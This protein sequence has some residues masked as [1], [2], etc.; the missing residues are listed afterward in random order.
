NKNWKH[1]Y[2]FIHYN[3][4]YHSNNYEGIYWY[5]K[6]ESPKLKVLTISSVEQDNITTLES[7]NLNLGDFTLCIPSDMTKTH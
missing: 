1:N 6:K 4:T 5:L 3:G 2:T 7:E